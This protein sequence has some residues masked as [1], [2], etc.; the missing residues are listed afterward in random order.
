MRHIET[1]KSTSP[2]AQSAVATEQASIAAVGCE[3]AAWSATAT[4][5]AANAAAGDQTSCS[6]GRWS[7]VLVVSSSF[8]HVKGSETCSVSPTAIQH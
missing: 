3:L 6:M 8:R 1:P 5:K 2:T 4:E 7:P